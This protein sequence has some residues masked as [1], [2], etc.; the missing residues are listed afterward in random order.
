MKITK[1]EFCK[2]NKQRVNVYLD[3]AFAFALFYDL[4]SERGIAKGKTLTESDVLE[5]KNA[6]MKLISTRAA[7]DILA[8]RGI[9]YGLLVERLQKKGIPEEFATKTAKYLEQ[10]KYINDEQYALSKA[11]YLEESKKYGK[12][13]I[14][15]ALM[16][17]KISK[18]LIYETLLKLPNDI[19]MEN[20]DEILANL[21]AKTDMSDYSQ[22][23]KMV[24]KIVRKGYSFDEINKAIARYNK[25]E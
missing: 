9:S 18:E 14:K 3:D 7:F 20:L 2:K 22:K 10:K 5:L 19:M 23:Q 6:D 21:V 17:D 16:Q 4:V 25:D 8:K 13:R 11:K 12:E 1:L 24:M 15:I